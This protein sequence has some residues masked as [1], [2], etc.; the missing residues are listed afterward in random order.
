VSG[1][2]RIIK[3]LHKLRPDGASSFL[4]PLFLC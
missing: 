4:P 2:G 3:F 1:R